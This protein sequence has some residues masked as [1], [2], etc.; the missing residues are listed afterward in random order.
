MKFGRNLPR[1]QVP[2]WA[3][4]YI[5]Y[6][7]LKKLIKAASDTGKDQDAIDTAGELNLGI[8]ICISN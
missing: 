7:G 1:N 8:I 4:H 3:S 5:N 6:K 2:E